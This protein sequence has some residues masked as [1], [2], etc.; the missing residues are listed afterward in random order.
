M[1]HFLFLLLIFVAVISLS[2]IQNYLP[3]SPTAEQEYFLGAVERLLNTYL[4]KCGLIL[5]GYAGTG[6]TSVIGALVKELSAQKRKF[7]LLTPT[8]KSAKVLQR[9]S[10]YSAFTIH[11]FI[12]QVVQKGGRRYFTRKENLYKN[13]LFIVDEVSMIS[14]E[15]KYFTEGNS[16]SLLDDLLSYIFEGE[17]CKLIFLGDQAQLPPVHSLLSPALDADVLKNEFDLKIAK[18]HFT[19]VHRQEQDSGILENATMLRKL[20]TG[21]RDD[22]SWN[23]E[24]FDFAKLS[25]YDLPE[26]YEEAIQKYGSDE[27]II[28]CRSNKQALMY[29]QA[30]RAKVHYLEDELNGGDRLMVVKNNYKYKIEDAGIDFIANGEAVSINR[31]IAREEKYGFQFADV[32]LHLDDYGF[33]F[34]AKLLI[35]VLNSPESALSEAQHTLLYETID[36]ELLEEYPSK[37]ERLEVL[38]NHPYLNALQ[39]KYAYAITGHKSQGGQWEVVMM[40]NGFAFDIDELQDQRWLYTAITRAKKQFYWLNFREKKED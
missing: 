30:I 27:V 33:D 32:D 13:T 8:G 36:A 23:W 6:K 28:L 11:K 1:C 22:V 15:E 34:S 35:D 25:A 37:K 38:R 17:N 39:V 5:N 2:K 40:D 18:C 14:G 29:N 21:K 9:Y 4:P 20:I 26:I 24:L 16:N 31:V 7:V 10:G 3:F 12:Y 19:E